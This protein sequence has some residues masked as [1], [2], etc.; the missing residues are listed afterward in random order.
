MVV[1]ALALATTDNLT[2][3]CSKLYPVELTG[4]VVMLVQLRLSVE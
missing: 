1:D 2:V 3:T 4:Y